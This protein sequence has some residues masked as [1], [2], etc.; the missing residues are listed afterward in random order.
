MGHLQK[1]AGLG[2]VPGEPFTDALLF[3]VPGEDQPQIAVRQRGDMSLLTVTSPANMEA[4]R[5]A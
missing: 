3:R 2:A 1:I 5:A 4:T